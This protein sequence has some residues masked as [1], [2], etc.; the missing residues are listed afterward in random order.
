MDDRDNLS[1]LET[2]AKKHFW[3]PRRSLPRGAKEGTAG[4][5]SLVHELADHYRGHKRLEEFDSGLILLVRR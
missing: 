3:D 1:L 5:S 2:I 4:V